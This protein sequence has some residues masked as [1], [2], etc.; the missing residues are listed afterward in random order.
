MTAFYL[1]VLHS[2]P[3][4]P[5]KTKVGSLGASAHHSPIFQSHANMST[6][7]YTVLSETSPTHRH[8]RLSVLKVRFFSS[9]L[10]WHP[11]GSPTLNPLH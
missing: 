5:P 4:W 11:L 8:Q 1:T 3:M 2:L 7:T 10:H 9:Q 6:E